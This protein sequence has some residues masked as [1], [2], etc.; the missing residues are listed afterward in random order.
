MREQCQRIPRVD[1]AAPAKSMAPCIFFNAS[2]SH[3]VRK[4][5][6]SRFVLIRQYPTE[7]HWFALRVSPEYSLF[8]DSDDCLLGSSG[9]PSFWYVTLVA[10][11]LIRFCARGSKKRPGGPDNPQRSS[12]DLQDR[13]KSFKLSKG[14]HF[15]LPLFF[16]GQLD[17]AE[18]IYLPG[19]R[20]AEA[21]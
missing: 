16:N 4:K 8:G 17:D 1:A 6:R 14:A 12:Q 10:L 20:N 2:F 18:G 11:S 5:W 15:V 9:C 7:P 19:N 13:E 21:S 3:G